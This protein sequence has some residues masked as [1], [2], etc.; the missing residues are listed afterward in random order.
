M[1][2]NKLALR[3]SLPE[4]GSRAGFPNVLF[5]INILEDGHSL[6]KRRLYQ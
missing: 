3:A 4:E 2:E 5:F 1:T 6:R